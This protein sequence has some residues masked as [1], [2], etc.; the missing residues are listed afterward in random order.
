MNAPASSWRIT[1]LWFLLALVAGALFA[2]AALPRIAPASDLWDYSQEARQIARAEGFTS[3]YT[4]P[5]LLGAD[6]PPFPVRWR[7]PLYAVLGALLLKL[8]IALPGGFLYLAAVARALLVALTHRLGARLHSPLVGAWAAACAL[9]CPLLLDFYNP[10]MSQV[11]AAALDLIAWML[12]LGSGGALA[13]GLAALAAAGA[14]YLRGETLLFVP[15]WLWVA[16]RPWSRAQGE[17]PR[18]RWPRALTFAC[19]FA[20]LCVPWMIVSQRAGLAIQGNPMLLYTPQY[21]GYSSSRM[22]GA[23]LPG[24]LEY[25]LRH[26]GT[27]AF[28]FMKDIAGYLLD[29]AD[30]L[31]PLVIGVGIAG[32][33]LGGLR[34]VRSFARRYSS[35]LLAIAVQILAMSALERSPR[36]LVPVVPFVLVLLGVVATPALERLA[37]N[38]ALV[39]LLFLVVFERGARV[40]SQRDDALRRFPPVPASTET[41]TTERARDWPREGLVLSDA[42]DWI[43]WR[44][45]RP[46]LF[47]PLMSQL[48]SLCAARPVAAIWLSPVARQRNIADGDTAWAG[49]MDRDDPIA[50][51][52]RPELLPGGARV[53]AR[54]HGE[55]FP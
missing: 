14:W 5:V 28:R 25:V 52:G 2:H 35:L 15:L 29:L 19:V 42:P 22:L 3:L 45:D 17:R 46:A 11:H 44:L 48:D 39:A 33:A 12:V 30:G 40:L 36:F 6:N 8:G 7:M 4:Y 9:V 31:G 38:R 50:G 27:F 55:S 16:A 32:M 21:P 49:K 1:V 54:P 26:P 10:G 41:A 37:R 18:T 20:A 47:F 51:F 34:D 23:S 13:A 43:A 24:I 53:Y